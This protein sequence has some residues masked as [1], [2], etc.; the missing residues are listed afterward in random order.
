MRAANESGV[1]PSCYSRAAAAKFVYLVKLLFALL[2]FLLQ[3]LS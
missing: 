2:L 3:T 1:A